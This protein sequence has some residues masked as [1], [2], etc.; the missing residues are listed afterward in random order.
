MTAGN[1]RY[2]IV[3]VSNIDNE[4]L[5]KLGKEWI[6]QLWLQAYN[7]IKEN[8]Q[9]FRLTKEEKQKLDNRNNNFLEYSPCEEEITLKM[10]FKGG[11]MEKWTTAELNQEIFDNK[12]SATTIGRAL[13]KI[14]NKYPEFVTIEKNKNG[15]YYLLP[16]RK[17]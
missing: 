13:S 17:K 1:R 9:K 3:P 15:R 12:S 11:I 4:K 5:E 8:P 7:E 16:I 6:K 10:D 2:W 14:K